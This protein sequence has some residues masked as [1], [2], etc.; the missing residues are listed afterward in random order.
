LGEKLGNTNLK[1]IKLYFK[2]PKVYS[3]GYFD[4]AHSLEKKLIYF[5]NA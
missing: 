1:D 2:K 5:L 3:K 4:L